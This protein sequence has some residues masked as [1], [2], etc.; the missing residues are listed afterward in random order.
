MR[1]LA[2][3]LAA[4]ASVALVALVAACSGTSPP[5]GPVSCGGEARQPIDC[6]SEVAYQGARTQG[7]F[8]VMQLASANAKHEEL[9]LRR[10]DEETERFIAMQT[11]LCRD[12]NAC[13]LDKD[14]YQREARAI[15]DRVSRVPELA[16]ALKNAKGD[17]E[18]KRIL[19]D[20]YRG[21]V[22]DE[23]RVEEIVFRMA[24]TAALP[25]TVG[26]GEIAVRPGAPVPTKARVAFD[27]DVSRDAYVYIFQKSPE[28]GVTVLFP[29]SRIGTQNP[30]KANERATIPSGGKRFVVNDKDLGLEHI[31]V[32]VS[33][34]PIPNL[35]ESLRKA[36]ASDVAS[37]KDDELLGSFAALDAPAADC[38]KSRG[39]DLEGGSGTP[40]SGPVCTKAR[41][42]EHE[43]A[44]GGGS[45]SLRTE[46]GDSHIVKSFPFE[47]TTEQAYLAKRSTSSR[48][49][50]RDATIEE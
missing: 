16:Q 47:H 50:T 46:P 33:K 48:P 23:Y 36:A 35:D 20:L 43:D 14:G 18:R 42:L 28:G 32:A 30:L 11:R 41:G 44:A 1:R 9:A 17:D 25:E 34:D 37:I 19:D 40:A 26:G 4:S 5:P 12:Y 27:L 10:V 21:T 6:S 45:F 7:G 22:R 2:R 13:V 24:M 38:G 49:K 39:L 3:A 15:R 8:G 31:Y 29:N